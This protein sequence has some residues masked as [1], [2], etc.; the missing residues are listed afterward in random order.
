MILVLKNYNEY[1]ASYNIYYFLIFIKQKGRIKVK[2]EKR[3]YTLDIWSSIYV[4]HVID[5]VWGP[6]ADLN[7]E[8]N[9]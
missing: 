2:K 7:L 8:C 6:T 1:A 5:P 9:G 3:V 4:T